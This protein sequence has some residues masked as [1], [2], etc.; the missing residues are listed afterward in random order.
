MF[1][2]KVKHLKNVLRGNDR[3]PTP[4]SSYVNE[5][6]TV[7]KN[8]FLKTSSHQLFYSLS[9]SLSLSGA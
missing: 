9:L 4:A 5:A 1:V 6:T 3:F 2:E 8:R 7:E